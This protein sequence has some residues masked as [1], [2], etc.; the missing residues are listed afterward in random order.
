[1][2]KLKY[3]TLDKNEQNKIKKKFYETEYGQ[4]IKKRLNRLFIIG[5]LG[6]LFS[7]ILF[8]FHSNRY[9]II[10]GIILLLASITFIIG[11]IFVRIDKINNYLI[12]N[13][14]K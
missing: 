2:Y 11:S 14:N 7:I 4:N 1:M 9:D 13:K 10:S 8:I 6:F 3:Y 5:I 12:K